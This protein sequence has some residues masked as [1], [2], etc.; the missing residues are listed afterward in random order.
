M[1]DV[2][3]S[4]IANITIVR[5]AGRID[6]AT[7]KLFEENLLTTIQS[8]PVKLIIDLSAV[9][10]VSSAGLRVFLVAA[11]TAKEYGRALAVCSVEPDVRELFDVT[12]FSSLL[13]LYAT[14]DD[15]CRAM[16]Q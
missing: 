13:G 12:G 8:R 10:Y 6:S 15:A 9:D 4:Q 1:L 14:L 5:P 2:T 3:T 11:K 16:G 7:A